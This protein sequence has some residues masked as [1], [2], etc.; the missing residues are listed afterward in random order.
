LENEKMYSECYA[1]AVKNFAPFPRAKLV[2][3]RVPDTL[4]TAPIGRVAYLSLDMNVAEPE[5]AALEHFWDKLS[6]GAPVLLDDYA[7]AN[8]PAQKAAHD[9]FARAHNVSIL[10]LPTGQGLL[11]KP[12]AGSAR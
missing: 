1:R 8:F 10:T 6:P 7:W 12:G 2:R 11:L 4:A 5:W 3:G 9:A